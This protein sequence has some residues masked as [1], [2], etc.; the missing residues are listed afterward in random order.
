[1]T[2]WTNIPKPGAQTYTRLNPLGKEQYDQS[3]ITYDSATTYYDGINLNQWTEVS[4][5]QGYGFLNWASMNMIWDS[6]DWQ[7]G[8]SASQWTNIP[9]PT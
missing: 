9:K 4:K 3:D 1:M 6:A 5:P 7:W 8:S 2:A